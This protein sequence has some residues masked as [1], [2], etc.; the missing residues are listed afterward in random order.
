MRPAA[1]RPPPG[2]QETPADKP[3]TENFF[4]SLAHGFS[5]HVKHCWAGRSRKKRGRG[6][7][8]MPLY[9]IA[10]LQQMAQEWIAL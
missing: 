1:H 3:L 8:R 7:D 2:A 10:E 6:I 5:Q 9:T 4:I